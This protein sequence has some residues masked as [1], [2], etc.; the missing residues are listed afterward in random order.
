MKE[1]LDKYASQIAALRASPD[2]GGQDYTAAPELAKA[3][4]VESAGS[5]DRLD[6]FAPDPESTLGADGLW[7]LSEETKRTDR[8]KA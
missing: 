7:D 5:T 3:R 6:L 8:V 2:K 4:L 1:L